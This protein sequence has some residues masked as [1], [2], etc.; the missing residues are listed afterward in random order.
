MHAPVKLMFRAGLLPDAALPAVERIHD[1]RGWAGRTDTSTPLI[2]VAIP[3]WRHDASALIDALAASASSASIEIV[4]LDDGSNDPALTRALVAAVDRAACHMHSVKV[5]LVT[6]HRNRGRAAARNAAIAHARADWILL[7][8]ADMAPDD[9]GFI[10]AYLD[11]IARHPAPA[12]VI[13][14]YSLRQASANPR[15]ALHRWQA[16]RSECLPAAA[17]M[18]SPGRHVFT[19][20]VLAHRAILDRIAFDEGFSGW[21]WEDTD[22][23]LRVAAEYPVFHIDNT[24]TH[25]GL[26][27]DAAL[28]AKY[29]RSATN[30]ARVLSRHPAEMAGTP[31]HRAARLA[32]AIPFRRPLAALAAGMASA[33]GLP[34]G[35]RGRALKAMRALSYAE[36]L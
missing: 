15:F 3:V 20:N 4:V 25:L 18:A 9:Q 21:G 16:L 28:I 19:S 13:G 6:A 1:G 8:D 26:D 7:L 34:I 24:A 23:G 12:L 2:S 5:R 30:F 14:G 32:R 27:E 17:R 29:R 35:L 22:W 36:G 31:L 11:A 10:A 33:R